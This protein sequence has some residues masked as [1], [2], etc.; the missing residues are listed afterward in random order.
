MRIHFRATVERVDE[1]GF[2]SRRREAHGSIS[3]I[4]RA[5]VRT[6]GGGGAEGRRSWSI[7]PITGIHLWFDREVTNLPHA[8]LLDRTVQWMFNKEAGKA[9]LQLVVSA[10]HDL[11]HLSRNEIVEIAVG[12]LR[13]VL[14]A[15]E[16]RELW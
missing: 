5:A 3:Y 16:G 10:S 13:A 2:T 1:T 7:R 9:Y 11:T 15:S 8:T 4:S 14:S 6:A 12:D